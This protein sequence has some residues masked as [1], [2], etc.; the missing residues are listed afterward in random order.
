MMA[1]CGRF[2]KLTTGAAANA[3]HGAAAVR[4][5]SRE[6]ESLNQAV[7]DM[8]GMLGLYREH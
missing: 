6:A 2:F 5:L 4:N 3:E 8:S 1:D 7:N